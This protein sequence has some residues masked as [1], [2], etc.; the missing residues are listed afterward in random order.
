MDNEGK[1]T[2]Q[3]SDTLGAME[4]PVDRYYGAQ[5]MRCLLNFRIGGTEE[6]MPKPLV[7]AMGILKKAAAEVNQ[8]YGLDSKISAAISS[9]ADEVIS[10]KLYDEGHFPLP[11]WQTG[12]GTQT[13][14]N[15]NEVIGNRA[16]EI[17]GGTVGTKD[18]VHPNDHV[19]KS[20][21]SN[22]TFPSAIHISVATALVTQLKPALTK[23]RDSLNE[24][25]IEWKNIIK[26]GR[27]HTQDAVPIT[28]GQE[29]SG[30]TQQLT[31][32][33]HRLDAVMPRVYQLALGGT[34]VGTG[35]NTRK[36]F[37][38][39]CVK[40]IS[41]LTS[42]PFVVAPNLF[43]ALAS[44]DAM[45]EV[46]G[47][48][49][50]V[51]TSLMKIANDIRFLGSGPRCGLG[52]LMLPENEPGSSIMPGKVNPTQCEAMTMICAQVMGNHFAVT[53]GGAN[54]HFELNVFKP[55]IASNVLRSIKLLT[56]GCTS[57][58]VNC[59]QGIKPNKE[60]MAK[61][62][63]ESLMLV[64]ALNPHIGYDKSALI[65]KTAH[66]NGTT[67]KQEALN[68]GI[69]EKDFDEWVRPEKMLGPS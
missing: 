13:N 14:M 57:F 19:N 31:N 44:R 49:N 53:T 48:L 66:L 64:T 62:V 8:E 29:F 67:L 42:L 59:V 34:A 21:S 20:Q 11:I 39:N 10:G 27:T 32:G 23:L 22:D 24:K 54:G 63:E 43:E 3:E 45:V 47:A 55:M 69:S 4:V 51:A 40:R 37:A 36:G 38:E 12:S 46:H 15:T 52:E 68:A 25:A 65:A 18:P 16:I 56:D 5:T 61:I 41:K 7:Q 17:L 26:I 60:K 1:K 33:L 6:R 28:L 58:C 9:A 30:Y 35:L 50:T 2:R